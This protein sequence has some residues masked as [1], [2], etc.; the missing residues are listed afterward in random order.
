MF[1]SEGPQVSQQMKKSSTMGS[2][3]RQV[4]VQAVKN[5]YTEEWGFASQWSG[6]PSC[7]TDSHP[8]HEASSALK[9]RTAQWLSQSWG[10]YRV[11]EDGRHLLTLNSD[12]DGTI[13]AGKP[14]KREVSYF[15]I[16]HDMLLYP[17]MC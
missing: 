10:W 9:L 13:Q 12:K 3:A 14:S 16:C 4:Q 6:F 11:N 17:F 7:S 5:K 1:Q 8:G 2:P 15:F